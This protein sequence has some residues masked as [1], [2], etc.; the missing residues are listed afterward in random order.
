MAIIIPAP[1]DTLGADNHAAMHGIV[2]VDTTAPTQTIAIPSSG[3]VGIGTSTPSSKL[4]V[5]GNLTCT[6]VVLTSG[7]G[8]IINC[9]SSNVFTLTPGTNIFVSGTGFAAGQ[10]A[11][12]IILTSGSS[13][14]TL[15]FGGGI[16]TATNTLTTGTQS[17]KYIV[18]R[19]VSDGNNLIEITRTGIL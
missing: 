16:R 1:T 7:T 15:T 19:Y 10:Y 5:A 12:L 8:I 18:L 14:D 4:A 11:D 13:S 17:G 9:A 2:A 6:P 3:K